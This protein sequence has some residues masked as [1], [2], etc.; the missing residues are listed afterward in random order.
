MQLDPCMWD[1]DNLS[2]CVSRDTHNAIHYGT[3]ALA[4]SIISILEYQ[5]HKIMVGG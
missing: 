2:C 4:H 1:L 3:P 5:G